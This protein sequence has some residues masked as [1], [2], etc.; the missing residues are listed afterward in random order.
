MI[1]TYNAYDPSGQL[2][3]GRI[4]AATADAARQSITAMGLAPTRIAKSQD[5]V[6]PWSKRNPSLKDKALFTQ[7]FAQLLG[8]GVSQGEALAVAART[9]TNA[10][11]RQTVER[12]RRDVDDGEPIEEVFGK[13]EHAKAFDPVFVAFLRMGRASGNLARPLKELGEMYKWQ[14][15][16]TGMVKKGLTLPTIIMVACIVVTYFIMGNVVPTFMK[17]LDGLHA[18]LPPL[19][20]AV[21]AISEVA[22]NPLYTA[23]ILLVLGLTVYSVLQYRKTPAGK[24]NTD[25]LLL[26][27]I[28]VGPLLRTFILARISRSIS[29]MLKNDIPLPETLQIAASIAG[30]AL[31]AQ[32]MHEICEAA[33]V[34]N[35]MYPVLLQYPKEFPEQFALQ[36]KAAEE[37]ANLKE[38]LSYLGEVYNDEVT[39][40]V[41]SL[42][43]TIEPVLMVML[44]SV[45]GV[46]V[47]SV[48]LPMTSMMQALEK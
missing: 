20:K 37:K 9:T 30:N 45:V 26:R 17:I 25:T 15:R 12:I 5:I 7:Q 39:N 21:K 32:H 46:I 3:K 38:T 24:L 11:L 4:D 36:F 35:R 33:L 28:I 6:L 2:R 23:G 34:G 43:A 27:L 40:Q 10:Y 29:V 13:K 1:W 22:S 42:T 44:G 47:V 41:E 31:Y 8:G 16:I 18:E 19:T 48:F 14:L